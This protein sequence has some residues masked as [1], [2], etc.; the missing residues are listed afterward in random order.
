MFRT[1][2]CDRC[3]YSLN[4]TRSAV[5]REGASGEADDGSV[6]L[7]CTTCASSYPL[8]GGTV[9]Y[10]ID[11]DVD[12]REGEQQHQEEWDLE[13]I[14]TDPTLPRSKDYECR[15]DTCPSRKPGFD[16]AKKEAV[17]YRA[18]NTYHLRYACC[19]CRKARWAI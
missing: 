7:K 3:G 19:V 17:L 9:I 8:P 10:G 2:T 12:S 13:A 16:A 4:V 1:F 18:P 11:L 6:S 14:L 5:P 15:N